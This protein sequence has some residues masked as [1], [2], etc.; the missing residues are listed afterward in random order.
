MV[1]VMVIQDNTLKQKLEN[2]YFVWGSG[3]TTL[4]N[5]LAEK[6]GFYVYHTDDSRSWHFKNTSPEHQPAMCRDVPDFWALEKDDAL[7]WEKSIVTEMTPMIVADLIYLSGKYEKIICEGDIDIDLIAPVVTNAVTISNYGDSYDF[8]NRPEQLHMIEEIKSRDISQDEKD[9]LIA[10][11]YSIVG[12]SSSKE[13]PKETVLYGI[14]EIIR[15][16]KTTV[17][18]TVAEVEKYWELSKK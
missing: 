6:Y 13:P 10:N 5:A 3:K 1:V 8:F 9:K 11:A 17:Y 16:N 12:G 4:A 18:D 7:N 14:K 2:I 15:T